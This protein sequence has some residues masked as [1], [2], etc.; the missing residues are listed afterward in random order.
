MLKVLVDFYRLK[1]VNSGLGYFSNQLGRALA[2]QGAKRVDF[3]FLL[4]KYF[5]FSPPISVNIIFASFLRIL[6]PKVNKTYDV[7]HSSSQLP[8]ILPPKKTKFILTIHDLNFLIEKKPK[9]RVT[10]LKK[11]QN[12]VDRADAI[13]SISYYT[14]S[15]IEQHIALHGKKVH[16]IYNG[17]ESPAKF[18][19]CRPQWASDKKFFFSIGYFSAKKNWEVLIDMMTEFPDYHLIISGFNDTA[20]GNQCKE[21]IQQKGLTDRIVLSGPISNEEKSWLY[22]NCA[23]FLFPSLAEGF[24]MPA[25]E[26]MKLGK[27]VFL[28]KFTSLLE[29]GGDAAFYFE[30]FDKRSMKLKI[31]K[32]LQTYNADRQAHQDKIQ[33]H[34]SN[35]DWDK[36]A[37]KYIELYKSF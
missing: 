26:A 36:A 34:A 22:A 19:P 37:K 14:K 1:E 18:A 8:K 31:T 15:L 16:V 25:V 7:W 32:G 20:Y 28:S 35:F 5:N 2:S 10:Y 12:K 24:G 30:N 3:T 29:I 11:L 9:K 6:F 4:P 33:S 23:A 17:V 13:T 21:I 27:P